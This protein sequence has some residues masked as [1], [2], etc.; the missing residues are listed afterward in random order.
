M[1]EEN[2][3]DNRPAPAAPKF[4]SSP[5]A[6]AADR[7]GPPESQGQRWVKYGSNVVLTVLVVVAIVGILVWFAQ[8]NDRPIDT[9]TSSA[10]SLKPQTTNI[11]DNLGQKVTLVSVFAPTKG[12][13]ADG[14]DRPQVIRDLLEEYR[15]RGKNIDVKV[16]D[17]VSDAAKVEALIDDVKAKY[18]GQETAYRD[19]LTKEYPKAYSA[20]NA[21]V[22][23]ELPKLKERMQ[24][25]DNPVSLLNLAVLRSALVDI[26]DQLQ[27]SKKTIE[28][29]LKE[30]LPNYKDAVDGVKRSMTQIASSFGELVEGFKSIKED[31]NLPA[32]LRQYMTASVEGY[33][34]TKKL[35]DEQIQK[36]DKLGSVE[37]LDELR[38]SLRT[39]ENKDKNAKPQDAI[40]VMGEKDMRVLWASQL[41]QAADKRNP[42]NGPNARPR[43]AGEQQL[44]GAILTLTA[45]KKTTVAFVRAGGPPLAQPEIPEFREA[46][47]L[48]GIAQ[49]MRTNGIEIVE[50][51]ASKWDSPSQ[52]PRAEMMNGPDATDEQLKDA[53]WVVIQFGRAQPGQGAMSLGP[54]LSEHLKAGGSAMVMFLPESDGLKEVLGDYGITVRTDAVIV[55]E[56][57]DLPEGRELEDIERARRMYQPLFILDEYGNHPLTKPLQALDFLIF[58]SAAIQVSGKATPLLPIPAEPKAWGETDRL[59]LRRNDATFDPNKEDPTKGDVGQPVYAGAAAEGEKGSRLVVFGTPQFATDQFLEMT[60]RSRDGRVARFPGNAELFLNS[61]YWLSKNDA[62]IAISP[63]AMEVS[64]IDPTMSK[65]TLRFWHVGVLMFGLPLFVVLAGVGVYMAR[66]E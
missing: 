62:M 29:T 43:F 11:I 26:P 13:P 60:D 49:R 9:T 40:L 6:S 45:P 4:L 7:H 15:R 57:M 10:Y 8:R 33:D 63:A 5:P 27:L 51:D 16:I 19:Y 52:D 2:K 42:M 21:F 22:E 50:K 12:Q 20:I 46:G 34:A 48:A 54:K 66:R 32:D 24:K 59:Q 55:H 38:K 17:K 56:K 64:R 58:Q 35:A 23:G 25:V 1:S 3:Q 28:T 44:T 53:V 31:Q 14:V 37:K 47:P 65:E 30:P 36:M 41:W 39:E 18:G 61:I